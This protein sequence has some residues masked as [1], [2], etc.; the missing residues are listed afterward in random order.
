MPKRRKISG[1]IAYYDIGPGF[2]GIT[3]DKGNQWR[4]VNTPNQLKTDGARVVCTVEEIADD[5]SIFM[6]GNAV[7]IISFDTPSPSV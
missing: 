1:R 2:W 7:Q 6:W 5:M 3:D 4:P